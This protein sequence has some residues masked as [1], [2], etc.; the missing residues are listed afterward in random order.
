MDNMS[1]VAVP[2]LPAVPLGAGIPRIIHQ[3][4]RSHDLPEE[5][6]ANVAAIEAMNP[7]W[8]HR[9]YDDAEIEAFIRESYGNEILGYYHRIDPRYGA[10]RADLFRY[11]LLYRVGG[12]Y[13]DIKSTTV[14]P[15]DETL[16]PDDL[17]LLSHWRNHA[18]GPRAG[19]GMHAELAATGRGEYQQWHVICAAG[20]PFLKAVI[21][22]V[23]RNIDAYRPWREKLGQHATVRVTGPIAYTLAILPIRHLHPHRLVQDESE[24]GLEYSI[25]PG[26]G[27]TRLFASHYVYVVRPIIAT[28]GLVGCGTQ[29][30]LA[31]R[32]ARNKAR[33]LF[34]ARRPRTG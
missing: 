10:A 8:E 15:L 28:T 33:E 14:R 5:L 1:S 29:F 22:R 21:E 4:F 32:W 26:F 16:R 24:I 12:V 2:K 31:A 3:T 6:R 20:H 23:L 11:L 19:W 18:G 27:H 9:L 30:Y 25:F 13:L 7:G 34:S 17:Y